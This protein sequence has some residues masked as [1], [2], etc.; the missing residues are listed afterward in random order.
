MRP[1]IFYG[2]IRKGRVLIQDADVGKMES[3]LR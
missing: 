3:V 2:K 1:V